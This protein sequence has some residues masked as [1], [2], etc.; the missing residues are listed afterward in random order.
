MPIAVVSPYGLNL[1]FAGKVSRNPLNKINARPVASI[2]DGNGNETMSAIPFGSAVVVNPDNTYSLWGA[3]G[4][5]I[6]AATFANFGGIAVS[7]VSQGLSYGV[8][9][10]VGSPGQFIPGMHCEALQQGSTTVL[11]TEGTPTANGLVYLVTV[12]GTTSPFGAFVATSA[13]A[14][15]TAIQ[16]TNARFTSGKQDTS[17]IVEITLLSQANA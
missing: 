16:L 5:G 3:S 7:E 17:G 2:L 1:G 9:S 4:T 10:N 12:A 13:P 8:G 14:G 6:S 15:G 11:C